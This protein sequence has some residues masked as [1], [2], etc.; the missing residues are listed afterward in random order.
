MNE[1][2]V[3]LLTG[4]RPGHRA[5]RP[6]GL[7]ATVAMI[8]STSRRDSADLVLDYPLWIAALRAVTKL[9]PDAQAVVRA[10]ATRVLGGWLGTRRGKALGDL[11]EYL[12]RLQREGDAMPAGE[13]AWRIAGK[14]VCLSTDEPWY[15]VGG[16]APYHD[17]WTTRFHCRPAD[18][19]RLL[20]ALE[21]ALRAAG[22]HILPG[23]G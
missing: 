9:F 23:D 7:D 2:T 3:R 1:R 11:D 12:D 13:A 5:P 10:P 8:L 6:A 20:A 15:A 14:P 16:P 18:A 17:S 4:D 19:G 22:G 21:T